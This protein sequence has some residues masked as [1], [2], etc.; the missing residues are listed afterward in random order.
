MAGIEEFRVDFGGGLVA[1]ADD[2]DF[3]GYVSGTGGFGGLDF[4]EELVE[5][6][7]QGIVVAGAENFGDEDAAGSEKGDGK[8]EGV[9]HEEGLLVGV[10][11]PRGTDIGRTVV[12][13]AVSRAD[14]R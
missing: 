13:D 14:E 12:E 2:E 9:E 7:E 3:G 6:P 11:S 1:T 8:R 5:Y 10:G 4:V